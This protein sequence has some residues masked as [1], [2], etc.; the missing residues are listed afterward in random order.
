MMRLSPVLVAELSADHIS[1]EQ[2]GLAAGLSAGAPTKAP[3]D[4]KMDQL[5]R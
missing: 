1:G 5:R 3:N 2:F 4:C